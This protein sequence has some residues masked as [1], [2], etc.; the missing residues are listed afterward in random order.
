M[1]DNKIYIIGSLG[2]ELIPDIANEIEKGTGH[3]CFDD[4][5]APGPRADDHWKE[6]EEKR[7]RTYAEALEGHAATHI[8]HFDKYHLDTSFAGVLI[9]PAGKS[10]HL[11]LGYMVG[12]GKRTY[13]LMNNPERWDLMYQFATGIALDM[14]Q[15]IE[16]IIEDCEKPHEK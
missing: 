12:M 16:M 11:E 8:F 9:L 2:N 4:W 14:E 5:F 6:Y 3:V 7:G 10:C 13:V 15:L 1:A